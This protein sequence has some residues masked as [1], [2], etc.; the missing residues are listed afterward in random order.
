MLESAAPWTSIRDVVEWVATRLARPDLGHRRAVPARRPGRPLRAVARDRLPARQPGRDSD[1]PRP[2]P[3]SRCPRRPTH[4]TLPRPRRPVLR[5]R[6]PRSTRSAPAS[7]RRASATCQLDC[8]NC[9]A[10]VAAGEASC[11]RCGTPTGAARTRSWA[12]RSTRSAPRPDRPMTTLI[13]I[14][15]VAALASL[16]CRGGRRP[17][18]R[19]RARLGRRHGAGH[20]AGRSTWR[21]AADAPSSMR[22]S[23]ASRRA[24]APR[25]SRSCHCARSSSAMRRGRTS[26]SSASPSP[27]ALLATYLLLLARRIRSTAWRRSSPLLA[28]GLVGFALGLDDRVDPLVPALQQP[29]LLTIHVG[30]AAARLCRRRGR[31]PGGA[32]PRSPSA[33]PATGSAGCRRRDAARASAIG[34][35]SSPS[36]S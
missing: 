26:T 36:R 15:I 14:L 23:R 29:L 20:R 18:C 9:G 13:P 2:S 4:P 32:R 28:A 11:Y 1:G 31:L 22:R 35:S 33:A 6:R 17:R 21:R 27:P 34:P 12:D 7:A 10:T 30:T 25:G 8:A 3:S 5:V 19:D 16:A 24:R